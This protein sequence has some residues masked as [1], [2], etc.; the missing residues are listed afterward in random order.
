MCF[1]QW[2]ITR[3]THARVRRGR[4]R[5]C[6]SFAKSKHS[7]QATCSLGESRSTTVTATV[8][9]SLEVPE[10]QSSAAVG[11]NVQ[12]ISTVTASYT[13]TI[14]AHRSGLIQWAPMFTRR[15]KVQQRQWTCAR[16]RPPVPVKMQP[17]QCLSLCLHRKAL[18][19]QI[20]GQILEVEC[21][22]TARRRRRAG[23]VP[24]PLP[25]TLAHRWRGRQ[26]WAVQAPPSQ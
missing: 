21:S 9:G 1:H 2:R 14:P 20:P 12:Q 7:A 23:R 26:R 19:S 5:N 4:W 10:G 18:P 6:V 3:V 17:G 13:A 16:F 25:V 22:Y 11:Y 8:T 15:R 24:A